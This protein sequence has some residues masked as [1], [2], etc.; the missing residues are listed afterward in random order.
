MKAIATNVTTLMN[1]LWASLEDAN[2]EVVYYRLKNQMRRRRYQRE[3]PWNHS[4][5]QAL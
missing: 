1:P 2:W 5:G 3:R 4:L